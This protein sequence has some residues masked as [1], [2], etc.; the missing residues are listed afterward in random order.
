LQRGA[1]LV[2]VLRPAADE[3]PGDVAHAVLRTQKIREN[4]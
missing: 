1:Q 4:T 3:Q 2:G